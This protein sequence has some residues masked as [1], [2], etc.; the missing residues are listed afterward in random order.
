[1]SLGDHLRELRRR[2]SWSALAIALGAVVGWV[3]YPQVF[4]VLAEPVRQVDGHLNFT[5]V[6]GAFDIKIR[7]SLFV[8]TLL[9][10]PIWLYQTWAF[11]APGLTGKE[12]RIGLG[13]VGA[14]VPLF[15]LGA[16]LAWSVFPNAVGLLLLATPEGAENIIDTPSYLT[17]VMQFMLIFGI[18]F[19]LPLIMVALT[20]AGVVRATTWRAGWRW[21][22]LGIFTFAAFATPSPDALSMVLM[23]LPI[24][25]LFALA[26]AVCFW[27]DRRRER[28]EAADDGAAHL[29]NSTSAAEGTSAE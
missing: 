19:L 6:M 3:L 22:I 9:A 21:A 29:P 4:A 1:M 27:F 10:S 20:W 7:V 28:R 26:L 25:G 15:A 23:A 24:C 2:A 14:G 11:L 16:W 18:A 17:F 12:K 13:F 8:G 5:N